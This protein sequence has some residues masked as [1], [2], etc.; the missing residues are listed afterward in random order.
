MTFVAGDETATFAIRLLD[1]VQYYLKS[2][3]KDLLE[4]QIKN[5]NGHKEVWIKRGR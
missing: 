1:Q 3:G 5:K 4:V 2:K